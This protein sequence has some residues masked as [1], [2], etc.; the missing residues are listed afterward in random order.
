MWLVIENILLAATD[1]GLSCALRIPH[2]DQP[3]R[4]LEA[5]GCPKGYLL[6][7]LLGIGYAAENTEYPEQLYP[8]FNKAVHWDKW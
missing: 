3:E 2:Q 1:E 4:V 6:P 8:D 7:C 5:V